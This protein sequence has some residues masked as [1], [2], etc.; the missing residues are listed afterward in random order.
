[1]SEDYEEDD[2]FLP[3]IEFDAVGGRVRVEENLSAY[4]G[5]IDLLK[6]QKAMGSHSKSIKKEIESRRDDED[7]LS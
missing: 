7:L 4:R 1:M 5:I 3:K 6:N 2:L